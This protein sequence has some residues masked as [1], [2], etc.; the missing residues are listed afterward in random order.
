MGQAEFAA[1][2]DHALNEEQTHQGGGVRADAGAVAGQREARDLGG[3]D[4]WQR[5]E[6]VILTDALHRQTFAVGVL[7]AKDE[8]DGPE[9]LTSNAAADQDVASV[10]VELVLLDAALTRL[11]AALF[12]VDAIAQLLG[13]EDLFRRAG[14]LDHEFLLGAGDGI[15]ELAHLFLYF[16]AGK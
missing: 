5:G 15:G 14:D 8:A 2:L 10:V 9:H 6:D 4:L 12:T 1:D 13:L 11:K 7:G 16:R 3:G